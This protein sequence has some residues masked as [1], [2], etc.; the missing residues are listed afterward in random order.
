[1]RR[2]GRSI[3]TA[4]PCCGRVSCGSI[5]RNIGFCSTSITWCPTVGPGRYWSVNWVAAYSGEA[6]EPLA[7]Q[8]VD[9]AAWQ[10]QVLGGPVGE[11][12][13]AFWRQQLHGAPPLLELPTDR[14]RPAV[15]SYRGRTH[16]G[17]LDAASTAALE[18][19][20]RST[21]TTLFMTLLAGFGGWLERLTGQR[22][23]VVGTPVANRG[24]R[25]FED[26]IGLFVNTL[27]LRLDL[28]GAP[29]V[30]DLLPRIRE[31]ALA[32]Y[33]HQ[34][35]PFERLVEV[36]AP[37]RSA[38]YS[39]VFQVFFA[40]QNAPPAHA[41]LPGLTLEPLEVDSGGARFDLAVAFWP[42]EDGGM[43]VGFE[44]NRDLF[45]ATTVTRLTAQ[46][47]HLLRGL[48]HA[49]ERPAAEIPMLSA[50]ETHQVAVAWN[51][52]AR[53]QDPPADF[54]HG[55]FWRCVEERPDDLALVQ[56]S[57]S[58]TYGELGAHVED[59][60]R[61]LTEHGVGP[62]HVVG[63]AMDRCPE[64]VVALLA[65]LTAGGAYLPLDPT[66][67]AE[68]LAFMVR[69]SG[70]PV[71]LVHGGIPE[72]LRAVEATVLEVVDSVPSAGLGKDPGTPA[73]QPDDLAYVIYTSG[74]TG[75]PKGVMVTHR[76]GVNFLAAM[77]RRIGLPDSPGTWLA[78]TSMSFDISVLELVWTLGRGFRVVLDEGA[79]S[80]GRGLLRGSDTVP[81]SPPASARPLDF[82][83]FY[84]ASES[85]EGTVQGGRYRLLLEGA[86]FADQHGFTAVWTP[87]R[88]FHAF[89]GLYPNPSVTGAAVAAVTENLAIR[90]GS[91]V[92]PLH[93]PVRVAE[94]W[95]V[96]DNLSDGRAAISFATG[97][98]ADD[99]IFAPE[100]FHQRKA[101]L[102]RELET[103]RAL[104]R[105]DP[106][107]RKGGNHQD[108]A[109]RIFPQPVQAELPFWLTAAGNPET[110]RA[111][112]QVGSNLLT[113]LLGQ[114]VED[115][116][117]KVAVY[118]E[119]RREAGHPG[120]GTVTVMLHTFV[121][122][123]LSVVREVVREPFRQYLKSASFLIANLARSMGW[124]D[125]L[126]GLSEDDMD[127]LLD[128]AFERYFETSGLFGTPETCL[129]M[130]E[131]LRAVG[132][133]EVGC[134]V[135]FG[136][137]EDLV[138]E[139]LPLLD[140]V[141]RRSIPRASGESQEIE[142]GRAVDPGPITHLQ[143]TPSQA[144]VLLADDG[145]DELWRQLEV[146]LLGG[147]SLPPALLPRL[148]EKTSAV[149][150]NMYGPTETTI[151]S[152]S[153]R[154]DP[155]R[156]TG[157][158]EPVLIGR[159]I[160]ETHVAVL[161]R[162]GV[163]APVGVAGELL[164]GGLGVTRGYLA[165]PA[166]TAERFVPDPT[167]GQS[168]AR[169]YRTGDL[170]RWAADGRLEFLGRTD[171]QVKVLGHRIELGEIEAVLG[172]QA[173]VREA[174]VKVHAGAGGEPRLV[175]YLVREE[176]SVPRLRVS[177][178]ERRRLV[179]DRRQFT[180]P[181]GMEVVHHDA[182]QA[183]ELYEEVFDG[184]MYDR[185]GVT[186]EDG[187][188]IFDVGANTGFF[189][190]FASQQCEPA[191]V[192][193]FEPI[194]PNFEILSTNI[195]LY[196]ANA[197]AFNCGVAAASGQADFTF[198][199]NIAGLSSRFADTDHD[200]RTVALVA[201]NLHAEGSLAEVSGEEMDA[202]LD[203][204]LRTETFACPLV[205]LSD[206][207][208]EQGVERIDVLKI[209]VEGS[210]I[211]VLHGIAED[212]WPKI[213]QMVLEVHSDEL[214]AGTRAL[215][216]PRGF[217]IAVDDFLIFD[218][219][220]GVGQREVEGVRIYM[221]YAVR[222]GW[223]AEG[224]SPAK[225]PVVDLTP[226]LLRR[227][228]GEELPGYMVPASYVFME[229]LPRTPNGK[230]D[231]RAL[232]APE[233]TARSVAGAYVA[234]TSATERQVAEVWR[235][236]LGV[237]TIGVS[238]NFFEVGGTSLT[239]V[240]ASRRL[241]SVFERPVPLVDMFRHPTVGSLAEYLNSGSAAQEASEAK[242][243]QGQERARKQAAVLE[244]RSS[245][246]DRQ[247]AA[248]ERIG[249]RGRR[250]SR[251]RRR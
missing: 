16:H 131:R 99:F 39:P 27:A 90:A 81:A 9:Y 227:Q 35:L 44:A 125:D 2:A 25:E 32:S 46:L 49:P 137:D 223:R 220:E 219:P 95:S 184:A 237:D 145:N 248:R 239:L 160:L 48:A 230:L 93:D 173:G 84:F 251:G 174:A 135:D 120:E 97:W 76:N 185:Y 102:E 232:V 3:S 62:G 71:L 225:A 201:Q 14:P 126:A 195:A 213:G 18:A 231:R 100:N 175:A 138:L 103:V 51:D 29:P 136:V 180:L 78:L 183:R 113:H 133:D 57:R 112:G 21:G 65:V 159:P 177:E 40:L 124:G 182:R 187:D 107:T 89:G 52:T 45:D 53:G 241:E 82:S 221:L 108:V 146:L 30:L 67:P 209:D 206:V 147:E 28:A 114:S 41:E 208:R 43:G 128:H 56:D 166:L 194:P 163:P 246:V 171:H 5:P 250:G 236:V 191:N 80:A 22:D 154:L 142:A 117:D 121:G 176:G 178:D 72:A 216:E 129:R 122:N 134:L 36:L 104:W 116:E 149:I 215:L 24:R 199:P 247:R 203:E 212:D 119:A 249:R 222:P 170:A 153:E 148:R 50:V 226:E 217:D 42:L 168:G 64:M 218:A 196:G 118:R 123:D 205:T 77:D 54:L 74:S 162:H 172:R 12:L 214:L 193:A 197:R 101:V 96:V 155:P 233:V 8:Y 87:E 75:R 229:K 109:V 188:C 26:L 115:L 238:D 152:T 204:Y 106:V 105:G 4:V 165:R 61:R 169:L 200:R 186:F 111:A 86:R 144:A 1:M 132:I 157:A 17:R 156:D 7:L 60:A 20:G 92:L 150:H 244:Q 245:A 234:P 63:L 141:R 19:L 98:H 88:H 211:E 47:L 91:V 235:E 167:V 179:A 59:L 6:L 181:N 38:S 15:Q 198:Y 94:E 33:A 140:E 37:E 243:E 161:D 83:L 79:G 58:L 190:M 68:R 85:A 210:E 110:F 192:Y 10:R 69:D 127:A 13:V 164:L 158:S 23:L 151:W 31:M 224:A 139:S 11:A 143:C 189:T 242:V 207:I 240:Q 55:A 202:A 70:A 130:V 228:V 34:E 66:Y 73:L